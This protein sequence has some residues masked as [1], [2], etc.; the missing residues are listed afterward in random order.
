MKHLIT[1]LVVLCLSYSAHGNEKT[2]QNFI[3][4]FNE[5]SQSEVIE[6]L[7][8]NMSQ[9]R[10]ETYGL[11]AYVGV[12]LN[13][14]N[15]YGKLK[16]LEYLPEKNNNDRI[17]V[18]SQNNNFEY[19][20][21][22]NKQSSPPHKINYSS[23]NDVELKNIKNASLTPK[24][25]SQEL[26]QFIDN[27]DN[28]NAFSGAVLVAKGQNVLFQKA[29]GYASKEWQGKKNLETKFSFGSMNKMFTAIAALQLIEKGKL[30]LDDKLVNFVD[31]SWLP[32]GD[33]DLITVRHLLTHTSG[34]GNFFNEEFNASNKEAYRDLSAYKPLVASTPLLFKPG[35][36][37]RYSNSGMLML[38]LIVESVTEESYYS[39]VDKHIY[40]KAGMQNS[41][42]FA[43]D[44]VNN[45]LA[46]GYL[47]RMHSS[48][49]VN[50]IYTRAIK[51]SP[52]G[53]G[54]S[55]VGDLHRFSLALTQFKLLNK[56]LTQAAYSEK[57]QYNS[58]PWYGY[59]FSVGGT[60]TNRV[61]G[62]G[63][64]YLGVDARL[65]I[66]LDDDFIVVILANQSDVVSPVRRKINELIS[67]YKP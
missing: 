30:K 41:G 64:A 5:G 37:N 23:F 54:F 10:I 25:F 20:L 29:V 17:R 65:D 62:H 48:G 44:D 7:S 14:K 26:A 50:S 9:S 63:G 60:D 61:I 21:V 31:K 33:T 6:Y 12:F 15:T 42:S 45:N 11:D 1:G 2:A 35:T 52:A 59:G 18:I 28:N 67:S 43:L 38:G 24:S 4:V 3:T 16:V 57:T 32:E 34:L 53:G 47:K 13:E 22:I 40:K 55:T 58:A 51:G 8:N 27:L 46:T 66:H 19:E 56:E 49:W 39:Y 36:R